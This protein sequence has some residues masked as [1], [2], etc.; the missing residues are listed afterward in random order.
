M[1]YRYMK[2]NCRVLLLLVIIEAIFIICFAARWRNSQ[3]L[4]KNSKAMV[5][6]LIR[7]HLLSEAA[8]MN[9]LNIKLMAG[10]VG[11][12]QQVFKTTTSTNILFLQKRT[13]GDLSLEEKNSLDVILK[14]KKNW[15]Q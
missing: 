4:Q 6:N 12:V 9:A 5:M 13:Y 3:A 11:T 14:N 10:D 1:A 8:V 7:S 15:G 2:Y